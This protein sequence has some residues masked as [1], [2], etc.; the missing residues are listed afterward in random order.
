MKVGC[1]RHN[2]WTHLFADKMVI[3]VQTYRLTIH[4][5]FFVDMQ[6]IATLKMR[7][8]RY[9]NTLF[10]GHFLYYLKTIYLLLGQRIMAKA[11]K[12]ARLCNKN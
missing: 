11:I 7:H 3:D 5:I 1:S 6:G 8:A 9:S 10:Y 4:V 12:I 2:S